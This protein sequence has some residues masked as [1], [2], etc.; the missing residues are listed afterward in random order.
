[1]ATRKKDV[2]T[3]L[4]GTTV[5]IDDKTI[6]C[7]ELPTYRQVIMAVLARLEEDKL[8]NGKDGKAIHRAAFATV[9][10]EIIRIYGDAKIGTKSCVT[11][12]KDVMDFFNEYGSVRTTPK[13][14]RDQPTGAVV[15]FKE[16]LEK[17]M[18]LW[19]DESKAV[20]C[21]DDKLFLDNMKGDRTFSMGGVDKKDAETKYQL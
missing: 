14:R 15:D 10:K 21:V 5:T 11:M 13:S 1:M 20:K 4:L 7:S 12:T 17:T 19:C 16:K 9:E 6:K 2:K 18:P 8:K 3:W